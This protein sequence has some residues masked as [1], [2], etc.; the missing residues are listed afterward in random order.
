MAIVCEICRVSFTKLI[1]NTH[2]KSHGISSTEYKTS[3][4]TESLSCPIY[5]KELSDTRK[6]KNNPNFGNTLTVES[7]NQISAAKKG[8]APWNKGL[9]IEPTTRLL[10][11]IMDREEKYQMGIL[12]RAKVN[13]SELTLGKIADG[14]RRYAEVH[15]DELSNRAK[16]AIATKVKNNVDLAFFK[17]KSHSEKSKQLISAAA[18]ETNKVSSIKARAR[19]EE[20]AKTIGMQIIE[21]ENLNYTLRCDVCHTQTIFHRQN[22]TESKVRSHLCPTCHPRTVNRSKKE[23]ELFEFVKTLAPDA[24]S[25][26]KFDPAKKYEVDIF[27]PSMNLGI[28]FNGLYW[29]SESVLKEK[30]GDNKKYNHAISKGIRLLVVMEDEFEYQEAIV[31]DRLRYILKQAPRRIFARKCRVEL[32]SSNQASIF[33]EQYHI[34]SKGRSNIRFGLFQENELISVMTFTKSNLSRKI[35]SWELNRFCS[36]PGVSVVGGASKLLRA[37]EKT[38]EPTTLVTYADRRWSEG[39]V[40][41]ALGFD[42]VGVTAPGY[43]YFLPNEGIRIHRFTLRKNSTDNPALTEYENRLMQGYHRIWDC[44]NKKYTKTYK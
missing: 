31:K 38:C 1:T 20:Y 27:I 23:K 41:E 22:L 25:S 18:V 44:G 29:H 43:W 26:Y 15:N 5:K 35:N 33:C 10:E 37:F 42:F 9:Q 39:K 16:K 3:Y 21:S 32:I 13:H 11:G 4:G 30:Q 14:V 7:K 17:G 28:E 2:L 40:Y 24:V 34:Q 8:R 19:H 12:K 36:I 6:G